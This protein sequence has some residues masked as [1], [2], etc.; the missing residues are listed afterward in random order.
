MLATIICRSLACRRVCAY[1]VLARVLCFGKVLPDKKKLCWGFCNARNAR[2]L[3]L[4]EL[5]DKA[6]VHDELTHCK[7]AIIDV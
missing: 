3:L 4:E 5:A 6:D 1:R 7:A 2:G